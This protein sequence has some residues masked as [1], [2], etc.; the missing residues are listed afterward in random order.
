MLVGLRQDFVMRKLVRK[1][2]IN[3]QAALRRFRKICCLNQSEV[4]PS[5]IVETIVTTFL[6][7]DVIGW[8]ALSFLS[9]PLFKQ[10]SISME[11]N[12]KRKCDVTLPWYLRT[13]F[14]ALSNDGRCMAYHIAPDCN[15][16]Q[17]S[18]TCYFFFHFSLF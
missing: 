12:R 13:N 6:H 1:L 4:Y 8:T 3:I 14:S 9:R 5:G 18:H 16:A 10:E 11:M 2:R 7:S 15:H 17:E